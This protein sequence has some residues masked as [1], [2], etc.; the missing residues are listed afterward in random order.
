MKSRLFYFICLASIFC[1]LGAE[2]PINPPSFSVDC[3]MDETV[4]QAPFECLDEASDPDGIYSPEEIK[5]VCTKTCETDADCPIVQCA[6]P[7]DISACGQEEP[8]QN[9]APIQSTCLWG[10]CVTIKCIEGLAK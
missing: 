5:K 4:C 7:I 2:T 8:S 3:E 6:E 10:Q 9:S 1:F